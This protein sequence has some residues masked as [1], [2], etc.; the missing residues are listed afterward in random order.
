LQ[1]QAPVHSMKLQTKHGHIVTS[2]NH[3]YN[4]SHQPI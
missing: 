2:K 4:M 3:N 1:L